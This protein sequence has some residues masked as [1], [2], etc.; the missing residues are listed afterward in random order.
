MG[1]DD[2]SLTE[3]SDADLPAR[4]TDIFDAEQRLAAKRLAAV[5]EIDRR[6]LPRC[7]GAASTVAWLRD[8]LRIKNATAAQMTRLA[9]VLA[10]PLPATAEAL[11][12][13][14]VN[15]EQAA[16]IADTITMLPSEIGPQ[17]RA[18]AEQVLLD[19]AGEF[20]PRQLGIL[21]ERVLDHVAPDVAEDLRRKA[22]EQA[23]ARAYRGRA[24]TLSQPAAGRVRLSGW[25]DTESA[26]IVTAAIGPLCV[27]RSSSPPVKAAST[28]AP[29]SSVAPTHWWMCAGCR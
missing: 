14:A 7:E 19:H 2:R 27:P 10:G 24:F 16:V 5:A 13:A 3:L 26:A 9:R 28:T 1:D 25:L 20:D 12:D 21:G 6:G 15:V 22:A 18:K 11:S 23:E 4:L 29:R 8:R 17:I